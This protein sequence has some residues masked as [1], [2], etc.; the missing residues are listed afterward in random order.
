LIAHSAHVSLGRTAHRGRNRAVFACGCVF[1]RGGPVEHNLRMDQER[2]AARVFL[3]AHDEFTGKAHIS[4]ELL[5]C[6]LAGAQLAELMVAGRLAMANGRV[7]VTEQSVPGSDAVASYVMDGIRQQKASHTV[8]TWTTQLGDPLFELVGRDLID[9]GI[10]RREAVRGVLRQRPDR[11]PAVDLL[12]A[13]APRIRLER[14]IRNP[15]ELDLAGGIVAGLLWSLG[16]DGILDPTIDRVDAR[17]LVDEVRD[18]LP[19][20]LA[21]LLAGIVASVSAV[22]LTVRR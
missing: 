14:M 20:D 16:V 11:F 2:L 10:L 19:P 12:R 3:I 22:S 8:R 13:A 9:R 5:R 21:Q 1:G 18:G 17:R 15:R 7:V 6:G 4:P